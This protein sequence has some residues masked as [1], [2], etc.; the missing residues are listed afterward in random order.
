VTGAGPWTF[1]V[2]PTDLAYGPAIARWLAGRGVKRAAVLYVNDEYGRSLAESFASTFAAGGGTVVARDPYLPETLEDEEALRT[3]LARAMRRGIDALVIGGTAEDARRIVPAARRAG[4]R[5]AIIGADG[6]LG[7]EEFGAGMD[8][9]Y[10]GAAFF[11]DSRSEAAGRFV[12][13]YRERWNE[14]P[15]ADGAL[16]YDAA[17]VVLRALAE[18]GTGRRQVRDYVAGIGTVTPPYEGATGS[19]RFDPNGDAADKAVAVG[20]V[21]NGRVSAAES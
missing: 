8:G 15:N 4:H 11:A 16:G 5:G 2:S 18:G 13:R 9:T 12:Q 21:R 1:R 10:V 3:Y 7:L 6:L 14:L 20:V 19:I 17:R